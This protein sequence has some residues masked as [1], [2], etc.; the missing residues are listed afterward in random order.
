MKEETIKRILSSIIIIPLSLFFIIKG[1]IYFIFF[2]FIFLTIS[3]YE[4]NKLASNKLTSILGILFLFLSTY[5]A[6]LMRGNS[7]S[8]LLIFLFVILL[9][10]STDVGGYVF[11]NLFKGPKLTKISPNK[12]Y[13]GVLGSYVFSLLFGFIF[14]YRFSNLIESKLNILF[15]NNFLN[16]FSLAIIILI[17]S[18]IS[19]I[20]DLTISFFKRLSKIKNTGKIIPG[21]GGLLNRTDGIIFV[22]PFTYLIINLL[23]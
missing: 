8:E 10:V 22:I 15:Y 16:T 11:G 23:K 3:C 18:S 20:G 17:I 5:L 19:Q 13:S 7:E 9:C 1:S 4:W 2:L 12:T 14:Y 21:H 6:F